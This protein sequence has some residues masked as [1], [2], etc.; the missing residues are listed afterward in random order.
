MRISAVLLSIAL[1][2]QSCF[3]QNVIREPDIDV[4]LNRIR[5]GAAKKVEVVQIP[6]EMFTRVRVTQEML[7]RTY[8]YKLI[9]R[10][11]SSYASS[12][13]A[14]LSSISVTADTDL[15]DLRWGVS[16]FDDAGHR[17]GSLYF[18]ASCARGAIDSQ[19]VNFKGNMCKWLYEN[20]SGVFK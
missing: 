4:L 13:E 12:L 14:A 20:F 17:I 1:A 5:V 8:H 7:E 9:I 15:A 3:A 18:D 10:D 11:T 16:L 6:P 2:I 19:P